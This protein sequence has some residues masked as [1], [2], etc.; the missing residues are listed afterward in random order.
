[1]MWGLS[2][3]QKFAD[4]EK[5]LIRLLVIDE[6][7]E[8]VK[9]HLEMMGSKHPLYNQYMVRY[10]IEIK[11]FDDAEKYVER[12]GSKH[13]YYDYYN[14]LVLDRKHPGKIISIEDANLRY[15]TRNK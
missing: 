12:M 7:L 3:K 8:G 14:K 15:G 9:K 6:D 4:L 1:M 2:K 10:S 13:P 11:D 5:L